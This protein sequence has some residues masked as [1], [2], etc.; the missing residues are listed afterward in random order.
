MMFHQVCVIFIAE[1][2]LSFWASMFWANRSFDKD[3]S[4][5]P[6][7]ATFEEPRTCAVASMIRKQSIVRVR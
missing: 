1:C 6:S 3:G 5:D 4:G 2:K 7:K